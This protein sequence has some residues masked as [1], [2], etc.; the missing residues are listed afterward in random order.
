MACE[1]NESKSKILWSFVDVGDVISLMC[2]GTFVGYVLK[3]KGKGHKTVMRKRYKR[4]EFVSQYSIY[5]IYYMSYTH[6]FHSVEIIFFDSS[7]RQPALWNK[8]NSKDSSIFICIC[9]FLNLLLT[10]NWLSFQKLKHVIV[11]KKYKKKV[12]K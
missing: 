9:K 5:N 11:K 2:V 12:Y 8:S 3:K 10:F 7:S 4:T 1:K 6:F